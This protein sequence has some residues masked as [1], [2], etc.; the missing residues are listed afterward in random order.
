M[1]L[2]LDFKKVLGSLVKGKIGSVVGIDIGASSIKMVQLRLARGAPIL[3]T[4]GELSLGPYARLPIGKAVRLPQEKIT[5]AVQDLIREAN[6]TAKNGSISIPFAS[7]LITVLTLPKVPEDQ[8][9]QIVPIEARKY[10][11]MAVSE[12]ALDWFVIPKD[13]SIQGE[14]DRVNPQTPLQ[15]KGEE[16]LLVAIHNNILQTHQSLATAVGVA[17]EFYEIEI[18]SG[19]RSSLPHGLGPML[20]VDIGAATTKMY[21][22]E[23]GV[24][25]L[26]HLLTMGG[27]Q[28]TDTLAVSMQW[29]FEK[30]ERVKRER[31]LLDASAFSG[32]ENAHVQQAMLSTL[33]RVFS[34]VNRVLLSYGQRYNKNI[35][36]VILAGG[37]ASL[38][39]LKDVARAALS[40]EVEMANPF[41]KTE[42]PAFMGNVLQE[43]GPGFA[44]SVG[45]A[46]RALKR[47]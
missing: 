33:T 31:G 12:V 44:V 42:A 45:L 17:A 47:E 32:D 5:E 8:L 11:P 15:A 9:Q 39:G 37:G 40:V 2:S 46:L 18:F 36:R 22:V 10:I 25:R 7:S 43:I 19:I 38:P 26:T 3:E 34:E 1:A 27:M 23:R 21:V 13:E 6:V 24:V 16:V 41:A 30:A 35:A 29:D 28:M 20:F 14:F 4:Y